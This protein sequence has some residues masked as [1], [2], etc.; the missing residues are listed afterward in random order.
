MST[1]VQ[2]G[3]TDYQEYDAAH[4]SSRE[5]YNVDEKAM[6]SKIQEQAQEAQIVF[7]R[8]QTQAHRDIRMVAGDQN[9]NT[10]QQNPFMSTPPAQN[11]LTFNKMLRADNMIGGFQRR[12]RMQSIVIPEHTENQK[13][14]D[15]LSKSIEWVFRRDDT[16]DKISSCFDAARHTG[17]CLQAVW[18]DKQED[19]VNGN[20]CTGRL[21]YDQILMHP[22]WQDPSLKD[23][24]WL[25]YRRWV[26]RDMAANVMPELR[27]EIMSMSQ[28]GGQGDNKYIMMPYAS[29]FSMRGMIAWDEYWNIETRNQA[30][31]KDTETGDMMLW[32]LEDE[33]AK[34]WEEKTEGRVKVVYRKVPTVRRTILI[35]NRPVFTEQKPWGLDVYPFVPYLVYFYPEL[36]DYGNRFQGTVRVCRDSQVMYNRRETANLAILESQIDSGLKFKEGALIKSENAFISGPGRMLVLDKRAQMSDVETIQPP[37]IDGSSMQNSQMLGD[38]INELMGVSDE[39][40]GIADS[41]DISGLLS[42]LRQGA[43]LTVL[44]LP[45][46]RLNFSQRLLTDICVTLIQS[47]FK[48]DKVKKILNDVPE[49]EFYNKDFQKYSCDVAQTTMTENQKQLEFVQLLQLQQITGIKIP[50]KLLVETATITNKSE[51]IKALEEQEQQQQQMQQQQ[52][53]IEVKQAEAAIS[54][55]QARAVNDVA[56]ARERETRSI[57]NIGLAQERAA[58]AAHDRAESQLTNV[59]TI[60]ELEGMEQQ[61]IIEAITFLEQRQKQEQ[62][63]DM[64]DTQQEA[65]IAS[66]RTNIKEQD[67]TQEQETTQELQNA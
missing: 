21:T 28:S 67:T 56:S 65:D 35:G 8:W 48:G 11:T 37:R 38:Q 1:L 41:N 61:Q 14:A 23:C 9:A 10:P 17:L 4:K 34:K 46:D 36:T 13:T 31:L 16:Y 30:Y 32:K 6:F 53:Q 58:Q 66:Q 22:Y 3:Y 12:N 50:A 54:A 43:G 60:K 29:N 27:K 57:S 45:F 42:K 44:Q 33:V 25:S 15:Q 5:G 49:K 2:S 40:L 7:Q 26:P 39:L 24:E 18:L 51:L 62:R 20:I 63:E 59:K 47:N 64:A 52:Q 19:P 55:M